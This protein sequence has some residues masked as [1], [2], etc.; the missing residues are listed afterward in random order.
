MKYN[1]EIERDA[2]ELTMYEVV[3]LVKEYVED[4]I[5]KKQLL[6]EINRLKEKYNAS[7]R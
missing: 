5:T 2:S 4:R 3:I 6:D 7:N 1:Y